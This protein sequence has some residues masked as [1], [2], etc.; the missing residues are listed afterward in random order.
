LKQYGIVAFLSNLEYVGHGRPEV[1]NGNGIR[2]KNRI[3]EREKYPLN[4]NPVDKCDASMSRNLDDF[5]N[6]GNMLLQVLFNAH[7]ERPGRHGTG[8]AGPFEPYL[9]DTIIFHA[10]QFNIAA[11]PLECRPHLFECFLNSCF[12]HGIPFLSLCVK[13]PDVWNIHLFEHL[14]KSIR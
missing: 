7:F 14:E 5:F 13:Q 10:H 6:L 8:P 2:Q 1:C 4:L 12:V 3:E 9:H 11:I